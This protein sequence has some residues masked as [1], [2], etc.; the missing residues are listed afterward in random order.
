[1]HTCKVNGD[2]NRMRHP[3]AKISK[4]VKLCI[5]G[6]NNEITINENANL[7]KL[8]IRIQGDGNRLCIGKH[9]KIRGKIL[10][11]GNGQTVSIGDYTTFRKVYLS[12]Q[13]Q[14][15]IIIGH[16]CMFSYGIEIRTTDAHSVVDLTTG[17]R[18]NKAA[19]VII[20]NHV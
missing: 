19:S 6:D 1:M 9:C 13:E 15:S 5:T 10:I 17:I 12:A 4:T 16:Y 14:C 3:L 18:T 2:G 8:D 11:K 7:N 20:G